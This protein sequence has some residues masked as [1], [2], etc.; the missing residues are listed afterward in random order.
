MGEPGLNHGQAL[1][2]GTWVSGDGF[3]RDELSA[4]VVHPS[5]YGQPSLSANTAG[6][7]LSRTGTRYSRE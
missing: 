3:L 7:H 2:V 6:W 5:T 1:P 4:W